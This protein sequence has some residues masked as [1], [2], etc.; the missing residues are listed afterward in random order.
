MASAAKGPKALIEFERGLI[1]DVAA[2]EF[3]GRRYFDLA[4]EML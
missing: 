3:F 1:D 2:L 4:A